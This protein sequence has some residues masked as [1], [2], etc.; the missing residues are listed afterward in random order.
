ME[1]KAK[2]ELNEMLN[3]EYRR[4]RMRMAYLK[5]RLRWKDRID[6]ELQ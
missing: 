3:R 4:W 2:E 1:N 5:H 6:I